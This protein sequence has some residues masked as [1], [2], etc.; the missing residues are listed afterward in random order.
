MNK[1][2]GS[3]LAFA[4]VSGSG[5]AMAQEEAV[6]DSIVVT[7][8]KRTETLQEVPAAVSAMSQETLT[9]SGA[10]GL[11][12]IA[13]MTPGL[14]FNTGNAGGLITP[15]LRGVTNTTTTTFDNNVG[16]FLDGVYLSAKSNLDIDTFN[17]ERVE[18]IKGP[19]SALY[20]NNAFAG[21]INYVL[22]KPT[23]KLSGRVRANVGSHGLRE[24]AAKI[25]GAVTDTLSVQ[26]VATYSH[27]GGTIKNENPKANERLGGWD[28][29]ESFSLNALWKPTD[30]LEAQLFYYHYK[31]KLDGSANYLYT[32]NC[33]GL[34]SRPGVDNIGGSDYRYYCGT[35][36]APDAV[37]VD[38][39]SYASRKTDLVLGKVSYDFD[40]FSVKYTGSYAKHDAEALQDHTINAYG[41]QRPGNLR[42]YTQ[43]YMGPVREISQEL[44]FESFDND[45]IDWAFGGYYYNRKGTQNAI[46]GYDYDQ[47]VNRTLDNRNIE[48][49]TMKSVFGMT[50]FKLH[51]DFEVEA[52]GRWTWEDKSAELINYVLDITRT[53]EADYSYGTYRITA[54]WSVTPDHKLYAVVASGT[55]S[56]GFNNTP[57]VEEQSFDPE[58]NTTFEI[59][60]KNQFF[61]GRLLFNAAGFII[62][63][64]EL[65]RNAP[66]AY[67]GQANFTT[68]I[69]SATVKGFEVEL[70]GRPVRNWDV[71]LA[72]SYTDSRWDDGTIDYS[73]TRTCATAADC[74]L[75]AVDG[76]I[77]ISG[78]RVPRTARDQVAFSTTYTVPLENGDL[79]FR[80]DVNYRSKQIVNSTVALQDTGRQTY[81]NA[82]IG[83]TT[84]AWELSV[85][86]KNIFDKRYIGSAVNEPEFN[87]STTYTTGFVN[88]GRTVGVSF[89]YNF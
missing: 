89:E 7:A 62:K 13:R 73:S 80:G 61:N 47:S 42:R 53:P 34:N 64:D 5:M 84:D 44:R 17:L 16:V 65:Q 70:A 51:E 54:N 88:N 86:A 85:W 82:R 78:L 48:K 38:P 15:T 2:M 49:T 41:A 36:K 83:Y 67:P 43:P 59:G 60:S 31:D 11:Q 1:T 46:G 37:N 79:Y 76:G 74:G 30:A 32:N 56:G 20:G 24:A 45:F 29:K 33:G 57:V 63:W 4:L 22:A 87:P 23:D 19:Q 68:N 35:L 9:R 55:K 77:D 69:G 18:V 50:T 12:D 6:I 21:A 14:Q 40:A 28:Y 71:S 26:G 39:I 52:Q 10:Q 3:V 58:K 8:R 66:S 75:T 81:A 25:S 72:Y 27:F